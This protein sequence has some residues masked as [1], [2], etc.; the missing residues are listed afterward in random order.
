[1]CKIHLFTTFYIEKKEARLNELLICLR[2]NLSNTAITSITVFNEGGDLSEFDSPKFKVNRI[3]KR[4][5]Y[6][7]FFNHINQY[8]NNFDIHIIANSDV[9]FDEH[10]AVLHHLDLKN[11]V[12][13]L[14]R[15]DTIESKRPKLYNHNDSQDVWIFKGRIRENLSVDFP[16]GVPRCDNRLFYE[17]QEAGYRVL[18]PAFSIKAYHIHKGQREL[19]YTEADNVYKILPPYRYLYPHNFFGFWGTLFFNLTHS[20]KL[21]TYRYDLKKLNRLWVIRLLRKIIK[22]ISGGKMPLIGYH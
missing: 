10:V 9:Y 16:L 17:M 3:A 14:S 18:N 19:V 1:M 8:G 11:S 5:T 6:Q 12:L 13:A 21:G 20:S 2:K 7:D 15:W 4:P 22:V